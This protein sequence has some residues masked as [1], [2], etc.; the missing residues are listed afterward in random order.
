MRR[1]EIVKLLRQDPPSTAR[2]SAQDD[3]LDL[4]NL[5]F[6]QILGADFYQKSREEG[7]LMIISDV[8][9]F[10]QFPTIEGKLGIAVMRLVRLHCRAH[11][12]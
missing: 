4:V 5:S 1:W 2:P 11:G 7:F 10:P 8:G 9:G 3:N 12:R 6:A